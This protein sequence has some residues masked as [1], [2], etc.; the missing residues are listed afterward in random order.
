M[1]IQLCGRDENV[2]DLNDQGLR[3]PLLWQKN[4]AAT[5]ISSSSVIVIWYDSYNIFFFPKNISKGPHGL[6]TAFKI[7]FLR[8]H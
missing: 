3:L 8:L 4:E 6:Y 2:F 5:Y 7:F 1:K